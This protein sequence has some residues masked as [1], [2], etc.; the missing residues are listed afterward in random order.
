MSNTVSLALPPDLLDRIDAA[1]LA[2]DRS[3][4]AMIR[5]LIHAALAHP[6]GELHAAPRRAGRLP[7]RT[8]GAAGGGEISDAPATS[9]VAEHGADYP[10]APSAPDV[11]SAAGAL[12]YIERTIMIQ[13]AANARQRA[14]R[15]REFAAKDEALAKAEAATASARR[16]GTRDAA[17]IEERQRTALERGGDR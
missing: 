2:E 7:R 8:G 17:E 6:S 9:A 3:R 4:S 10:T 16:D 1:A 15:A 13:E 5:R 14:A 11:S 12:S